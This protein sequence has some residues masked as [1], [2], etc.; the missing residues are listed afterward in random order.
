MLENT[1]DKNKIISFEVEWISVKFIKEENKIWLTKKE[2]AKVFT[3][4][5]ETIK[6]E[7]AYNEYR[8]IQVWKKV[9]K[10]YSIDSVIVLGY[11]LKRYKETKMLVLLNRY[12]KTHNSSETLL[13]RMKKL[14]SQIEKYTLV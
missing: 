14:Y 12:F 2:L 1:I 4:D 7:L 5:K 11:K 3:A 9:K 8:E 13:T 10:F 6:H